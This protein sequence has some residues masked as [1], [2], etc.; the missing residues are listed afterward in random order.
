MGSH[1]HFY[2]TK[3]QTDINRALQELRQREFEAGR[4]YPRMDMDLFEFPPT[5][6]SIAPGAKHPSIK[7]VCDDAA[8]DG[9]GSIIDIEEVIDAIR[10]S[11]SYGLSPYEV[12]EFFNTDQLSREVAETLIKEEEFDS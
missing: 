12:I 10:H 3:Y 1:P 8:E 4:Y 6:D 5:K 7:A 9:T 2:M 11:A